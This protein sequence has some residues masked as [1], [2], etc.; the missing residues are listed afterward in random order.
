MSKSHLHPKVNRTYHQFAQISEMKIVQNFF[1]KPIDKSA[2]IWYNKRLGVLAA[3]QGWPYAVLPKPEYIGNFFPT[4]RPSLQ[5]PHFPETQ[6]LFCAAL[7]VDKSRPS[8]LAPVRKLSRKNSG[9]QLNHLF[10]K[11]LGRICF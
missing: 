5:F 1:R 10:P 6:E 9:P 7:T 8:K 3:R 2:E 4:L 11:T